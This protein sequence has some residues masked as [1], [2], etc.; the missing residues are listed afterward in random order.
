MNQTYFPIEFHTEV[1]KL[2]SQAEPEARQ[3]LHD[4]GQGHQDI[5]GAAVAVEPLADDGATFEAQVT[6]Y[7]RPE[8]ISASEKA[9]A[10]QIALKGALS[11]IE[12]Q[13]RQERDKRGEPWKRPDLPDR[14]EMPT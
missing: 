3:R 2:A 5:T 8:N 14:D 13:V 7:M 1:S 4:L 9:E 11:A 12:R 10:P 6:L